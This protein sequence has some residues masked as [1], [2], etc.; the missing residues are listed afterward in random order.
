[1]ELL[2]KSR[3]A[4][5]TDDFV[6]GVFSLYFADLSG[7]DW[8]PDNSFDMW[9]LVCEGRKAGESADFMALAIICYLDIIYGLSGTC[10]LGE[11]IETVKA[12]TTKGNEYEAFLDSLHLATLIAHDG[13][14]ACYEAGYEAEIEAEAQPAPTAPLTFGL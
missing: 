3:A 9:R 7:G 5:K 1:M 2:T 11:D 13:E 6:A 14:A 8:E 12:I 4:G 10:W